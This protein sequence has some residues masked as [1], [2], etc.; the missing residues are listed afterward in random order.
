MLRTV[1]SEKDGRRQCGV[2]RDIMYRRVR[3]DEVKVMRIVGVSVVGCPGS[4]DG[5]FIELR[6]TR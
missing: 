6:I 5:E 4:A 1:S 2:R 3:V